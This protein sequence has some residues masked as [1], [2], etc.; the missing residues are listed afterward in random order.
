MQLNPRLALLLTLQQALPWWFAL[1]VVLRDLLIVGGALAFHFTVGRVEMAPSTISKLNT[2]L[3]FL[4]LLGVLAARAGHV[5]G[6]AWLDLLMLATLAT[7]VLSGA[8]YVLV[9]SRKAAQARR[10]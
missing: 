7:I 8:Q 10:G 5:P 4:L 9:W 2:A 3:Q 1:A 6:G